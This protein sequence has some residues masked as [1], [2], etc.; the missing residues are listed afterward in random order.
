VAGNSSESFKSLKLYSEFV[1][2]DKNC[3]ENQGMTKI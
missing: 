2:V 3:I 1:D